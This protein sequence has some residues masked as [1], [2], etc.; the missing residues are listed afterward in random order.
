MSLQIII[1]ENEE[2]MKPSE[3]NVFKENIQKIILKK[4]ITQID[5]DEL[6]KN[7]GELQ[8]YLVVADRKK[9]KEYFDIFI[10]LNF[11]ESFNILLDKK[12]DGIIYSMLQLVN[13]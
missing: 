4:Q 7:L 10:K 3:L 9:M 8:G 13:F 5:I 12:I 6:N 11:L 2:R 1:P